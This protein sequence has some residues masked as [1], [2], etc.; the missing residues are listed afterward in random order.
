[1]VFAKERKMI[2][3]LTKLEIAQ[4]EVPLVAIA[5]NNQIA[6]RDG[7]MIYDPDPPMQQ[8]ARAIA[9]TVGR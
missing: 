5:E 3:L 9:A 2:G 6:L 7:P 4:I 8:H 1:M